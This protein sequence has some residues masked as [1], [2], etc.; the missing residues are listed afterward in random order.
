MFAPSIQTCP[1]YKGKLPEGLQL[2]QAH[3]LLHELLNPVV[4]GTAV[5]AQVGAEA[6]RLM[7]RG[8]GIVDVCTGPPHR[9]STMLGKV[10][11]ST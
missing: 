2:N 6:H 4:G 11:P 7:H 9:L 8:V 5:D 1:M 10:Q 3:D